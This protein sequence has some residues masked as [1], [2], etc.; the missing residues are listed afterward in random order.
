METEPNR[1]GVMVVRVWIEVESGGLRAR[2]TGTHDIAHD[3]ETTV[4]AATVDDIVA[5]VRDWVEAFTA[6]P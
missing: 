4:T 1:T 3:E 6:Q 2:L 5:I